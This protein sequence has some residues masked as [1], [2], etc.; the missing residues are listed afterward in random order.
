M[1]KKTTPSLWAQIDDHLPPMYIF[2]MPP[3]EAIHPWLHSHMYCL[4]G[5]LGYV[6][7]DVFRRFQISKSSRAGGIFRHDGRDVSLSIVH[8]S[9]T[10]VFP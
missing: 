6:V 4:Y 9:K 8:V 2:A 1:T 7:A 10:Q 5:G 3:L